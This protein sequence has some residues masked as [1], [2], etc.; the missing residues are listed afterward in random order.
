EAVSTSMV[1]TASS[2]EDR[3][4]FTVVDRGDPVDTNAMW[5]VIRNSYMPIDTNTT[6]RGFTLAAAPIGSDRAFNGD[7]GAMLM[8]GLTGHN[9]GT[10]DGL[11]D[12]VL[13]YNPTNQMWDV[14]YLDTTNQWRE[15]D[16][17]LSTRIVP[18]GRGYFLLNNSATTK[19]TAFIGPVGNKLASSVEV[20][21][22]KW[23]MI[24][25]SE[26]AVLTLEQAFIQLNGSSLTGSFDETQADLIVKINSDGSFRRLLYAGD[27]T[28]RSLDPQD[29]GEVA[30]DTV[31]PGES[32]Y[33]FRY[34]A[35]MTI[36]F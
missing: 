20:L 24:T 5:G 34:G 2:S 16:T 18:P 33:F 6:Q 17:T 22:G 15:S 32:F 26:G 3:R 7:F 29:F 27:N 36:N 13:I 14:L 10:M 25:L 8:E 11:G 9:G 1:F 19:E 28:W 4:Y 21:S 31:N 30:T 35:D 23:N 12:E